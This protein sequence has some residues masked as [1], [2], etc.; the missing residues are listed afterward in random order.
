M[1]TKR[2]SVRNYECPACLYLNATYL[3]FCFKRQSLLSIGVTLLSNFNI[4]ARIRQPPSETQINQDEERP[5]KGF[6]PN[7]GGGDSKV[8]N[9]MYRFS[10]FRCVYAPSGG[11]KE[12]NQPQPEGKRSA[13]SEVRG[14]SPK[15]I[16]EIFF[17]LISL[18]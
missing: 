14:F 9:F 11:W 17:L 13:W 8:E 18:I 10:L 16:F 7:R 4:S 6:P 3:K 12:R 2:M 1:P 15:I 5:N